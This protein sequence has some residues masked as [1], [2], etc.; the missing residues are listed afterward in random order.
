MVYS[1]NCH[2]DYHYSNKKISTD[3]GCRHTSFVRINIPKITCLRVSSYS[4]PTNLRDPITSVYTLKQTFRSM[5]HSYPFLCLIRGFVPIKVSFT[6]H[7]C[8]Q[9]YFSLAI[10]LFHSGSSTILRKEFRAIIHIIK[11]I[12]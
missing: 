4:F 5:I 10:L 12:V 11:S 2:L 6:I 7:S 1:L 9:L 8:L 3:Y